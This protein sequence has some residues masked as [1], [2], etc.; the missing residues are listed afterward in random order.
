MG[1]KN[2]SAVLKYFQDQNR[3]FSANEISQTL[4]D[5]GKNAIMTAID[6]LVE[7]KKVMEKT[8]GKQKVY[9]IVQDDDGNKGNMDME[10]MELDSKIEHVTGEIKKAE[11]ELKSNE[12][13][14]KELEN[15]PTTEEAIKEKEELEKCV[16]RLEE[17]FNDLSNSKVKISDKEKETIKKENEKCMKEYRKRKRICMDIVNSILENYPKTKKAFLEEV[18]IETDEDVNCPFIKSG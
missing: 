11:Q 13:L 2:K 8:Y 6:E 1:S 15:Q 10:L 4:K 18:G 5:I 12:A 3:P 17:K 7:E 16:N 9:C 14:L